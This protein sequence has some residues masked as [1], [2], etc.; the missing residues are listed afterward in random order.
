M[1]KICAI[2]AETNGN[3]KINNIQEEIKINNEVDEWIKQI[4][5]NVKKNKRNHR[6]D[7][8]KTEEY[9]YAQAKIKMH[10]YT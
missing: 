10:I 1:S 9:K 6:T 4:E 5:K 3:I 8:K 7:R 2:Y